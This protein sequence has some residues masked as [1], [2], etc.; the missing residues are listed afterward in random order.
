MIESLIVAV[1]GFESDSS[2]A[3]TRRLLGLPQVAAIACAGPVFDLVASII[4]ANA[5]PVRAILF[6]KQPG[7]NWDLGYHQDR[8]IAIK[9]RREVEGFHGWSIKEGVPHVLPPANVLENMVSARI[10]LDD[11]GPDNGPLRISPGTHKL[12]IIDK[13]DVPAVARKHGEVVCTDMAGSVLL[14]RP[15]LLHAS[16]KALAPSHRRVIHIEYSAPALPGGLEWY[17][18]ALPGTPP[19]C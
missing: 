15:L 12:G 14:M 4:G 18:A 3:G 16:S 11:C 7:V 9:E 5:F 17:E 19:G 2:R 1:E 10:H 6:D 13:H 8:A